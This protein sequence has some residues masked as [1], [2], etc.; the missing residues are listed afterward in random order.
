MYMCRYT[1]M[2]ET[3]ITCKHIMTSKHVEVR[4]SLEFMTVAKFG[5]LSAL[6]AYAKIWLMLICCE[7]E[8]TVHLLKSTAEVVQTNCG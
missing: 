2:H 3:H 7:R 4:L 6:F 1:S 5:F 8:N